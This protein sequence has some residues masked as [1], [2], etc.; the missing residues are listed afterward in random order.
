MSELLLYVGGP[1]LLVVLAWIVGGARERSHLA[2]L[3]RREL[4]LKGMLVSDLRSY[5]APQSEPPAGLVLGE[6]V[7]ASDYLKTF[8]ASLRN[9]FGGE[10][11]SYGVL[12]SRARREA[13]CR[14]MERGQQLGY[15]AV[16]NVRVETADIGGNASAGQGTPMAAVLASG[17]GY[18][19]RAVG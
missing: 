10:V 1:A 3:Q 11:R 9:F 16:C 4:A 6:A 2:S 15:D 18:R 12:V 17:T 13:I 8:L 19:R 5:L 14:M 7:I